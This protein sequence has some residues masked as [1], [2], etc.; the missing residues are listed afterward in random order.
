MYKRLELILNQ[1]IMKREQKHETDYIQKYQDEGYTTNY[2]FENGTN[3]TLR[4]YCKTI[5][6]FF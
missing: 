4:M 2:L 3:T 6:L 5:F 1:K